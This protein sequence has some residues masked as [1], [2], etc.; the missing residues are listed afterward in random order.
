MHAI[1]RFLHFLL[2]FIVG[3]AWEVAAGLAVTLVVLGLVSHLWRGSELLGF[4]LV[5]VVIVLTWWSLER[6]AARR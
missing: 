5:A 3:D 1:R 4:V 2:D 6:A